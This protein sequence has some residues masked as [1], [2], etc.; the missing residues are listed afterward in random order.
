MPKQVGDITRRGGWGDIA[1]T[2]S[3]EQQR[4][5]DSMDRY[6]C[7]SNMYQNSV[8]TN[9]S[10]EKSSLVRSS[11]SKYVLFKFLTIY[12]KINLY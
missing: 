8:Q 1:G 7:S 12:I 4:Q 6:Q 5:Y 9:R 11:S 2:N 3:A 10:N